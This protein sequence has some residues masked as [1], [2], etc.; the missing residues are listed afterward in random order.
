MCPVMMTALSGVQW[1]GGRGGV[2]VG[3]IRGRVLVCWEV[4]WKG[5]HGVGKS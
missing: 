2:D 4:Q 3:Q 1:M 5:S